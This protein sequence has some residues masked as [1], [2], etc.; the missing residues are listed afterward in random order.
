MKSGWKIILLVVLIAILL[1]AVCMGVGMMTGAD[2]TRI[3]STLDDKYHVDMYYQY[4]MEVW[5]LLQ[6]ELL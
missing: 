4:F 6:A 2:F 3:W 1:G 5:S